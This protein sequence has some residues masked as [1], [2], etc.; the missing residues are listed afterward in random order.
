MSRLHAARLILLANA[1]FSALNG[2]LLLLFPRTIAAWLGTADS[3]IYPLLGAGLVVFGAAVALV[4]RRPTPSALLLITGADLAWVGTTLLTAVAL[5]A[6]MTATGW[7]VILGT[8]AVVASFAWRQLRAL[9]REFAVEGGGLDEYE[10]CLGADTPLSA[11]ALWAVVADLESIRLYSPDLVQST[12]TA[13]ER[14]GIG[15]V[16][17]CTNRR[18]ESW[19]ERCDTW[20]EGESFSMTFLTDAPGFPFPFVS[21]RG[22]WRVTPQDRGG[23]VEVWWRVVPRHRW[24]AGLV[25]PMMAV[26]ARRQIGDVLARMVLAADARSPH[27]IRSEARPRLALSPC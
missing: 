17:S 6:G 4:A 7:G 21:M 20:H 15:C 25:I 8:N 24:A 11:P 22:G 14:P 13:G 18:G 3:V 1:A 19:A 16:R 23:R 10:I 9:R 12:L 5:H 27:T 2:F 26:T